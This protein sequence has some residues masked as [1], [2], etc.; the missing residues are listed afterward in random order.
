LNPTAD[1]LLARFNLVVS[2]GGISSGL[3]NL[4]A[5]PGNAEELRRQTVMAYERL[6]NESTVG[7]IF[8]P[9]RGTFRWRQAGSSDPF[10]EIILDPAAPGGSSALVYLETPLRQTFRVF[11]L[12]QLTAPDADVPA[13]N[14]D[15]EFTIIYVAPAPELADLNVGITVGQLAKNVYDGVYALRG[16]SGE[17]VPMRVRYDEVALLAMTDLVRLRL[18][19]PVEDARDFLE[20][21]I[22]A[23]TGWV[24]ALDSD[25]AVSPV[26]QI[27]PSSTVSLPVINNE[28]TEPSSNWDAGQRIINILRF[29]YPRDFS[30]ADADVSAYPDPPQSSPADPAEERQ[31]VVK[32]QSILLEYR[33]EVSIARH[34]E[35]ALELDGH[36]FAAIGKLPLIA[37]EAT[38]PPQLNIRPRGGRLRPSPVTSA[39]VVR[40]GAYVQPVT[41]DIA[42]EQGYQLAQLRQLHLHNRYSLGAPAFSANVMRTALP[43]LRAGSWVIVGLSWL[44][45]Y[46]TQRRGLVALGQVLSL[47]DLDCAWRNVLIE[48]VVPLAES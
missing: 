41:D 45:D 1:F 15:I 24:P 26:S 22:Y 16:P 18:S 13:H 42:D 29:T 10:T 33:D 8:I 5:V 35:Q 6:G 20:S 11:T 21:M 39:P 44:P 34:G 9:S 14:Q 27:A 38:L 3:L 47:G 25:G 48:L 32:S 31:K 46:I 7:D 17:L 30:F 12:L 43:L 37:A 36:A 19:E 40:S 2:I 28:V 23:P 4:L